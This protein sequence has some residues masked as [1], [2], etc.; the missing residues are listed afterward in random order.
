EGME[1]LVV[2][3]YEQ[4]FQDTAL[5]AQLTLLE[6]PNLLAVLAW[7]QETA[8]P[9]QVVALAARVETLFANLG[10]PHALAQATAIRAQSAQALAGWSHARFLAES[11]H[12]DRLLERGDLHAAHSAAQRHL[13]RC[14]AA[15]DTAYRSAAYD[16]ASAYWQLGRTLESLGA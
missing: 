3:L 14:L 16:I 1:Q 4:R 9:E 6:L 13:E 12:I 7:L 11:E 8:L 10:R 5:A 15:G 2:F